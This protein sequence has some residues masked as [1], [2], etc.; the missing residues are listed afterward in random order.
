MSYIYVP[1]ILKLH[2]YGHIVCVI[3]CGFLSEQKLI[4]FEID[5][6]LKDFAFLAV[7]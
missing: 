5:Q 2:A 7:Q 1:Y 6:L 3:L 4:F